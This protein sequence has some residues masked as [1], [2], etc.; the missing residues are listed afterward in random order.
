MWHPITCELSAT[1]QCDVA[2]V[3][4]G[5]IGASVALHLAAA[6]AAKGKPN[7]KPN[8]TTAENGQRMDKALC[9]LRQIKRR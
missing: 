8:G 9:E 6:G 1:R 4:G 3:G 7:R 2:I 5:V